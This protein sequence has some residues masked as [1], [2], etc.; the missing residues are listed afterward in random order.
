MAVNASQ[1]GC[2]QMPI[3]HC[4]KGM[5]TRSFQKRRLYNKQSI[6]CVLSEMSDL[7]ARGTTFPFQICKAMPSKKLLVKRM[8]NEWDPRKPWALEPDNSG[9]TQTLPLAAATLGK[10]PFLPMPQFPELERRDNNTQRFVVRTK[11]RTQVQHFIP[12][13]HILVNK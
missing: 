3:M 4:P 6:H 1:P 7:L 11:E 9:L 5:E 2:S 12:A 10:L 13:G 8:E